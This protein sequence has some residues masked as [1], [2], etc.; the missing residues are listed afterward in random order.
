[1]IKKRSETAVTYKPQIHGGEDFLIFYDMMKPED[2]A[3][4]IGHFRLATLL[5]GASIGEHLHDCDEEIY[6]IY[7]GEG[8]LTF[9]GIPH[10]VTEGDFSLVTVG[11]KHGLKNTGQKE[12]K[13]IIVKVGKKV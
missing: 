9:D 11:H 1:M 4:G 6:C 13:F 3:F 7:E 8:T 12:L 10:P 5:P 2:S